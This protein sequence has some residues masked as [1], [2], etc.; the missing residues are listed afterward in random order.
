[1][2]LE[3][4]LNKIEEKKGT[5]DEKEEV[6]NEL[7]F[8]NPFI[9][10]YSTEL[11]EKTE[12]AKQFEKAVCSQN[13]NMNT[14][15]PYEGII[16]EINFYNDNYYRI[17]LLIDLYDKKEDE[18]YYVNQEYVFGGD[19]DDFNMK[20]LVNL[21]SSINNFQLNWIDSNSYESICESMQF[22]T[23]AKVSVI[24]RVSK[25]GKYYFEIEVIGEYNS[26]TNRVE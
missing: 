23:G 26:K 12:A 7:S 4:E 24:Q 20:K 5:Y 18:K 16:K 11:S 8:S 1:M 3:E 6:E 17:Q 14:G 15:V 19:Y 21:L 9:G 25:N 13:P 22:L 2:N 10:N